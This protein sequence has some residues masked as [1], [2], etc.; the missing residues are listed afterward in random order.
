VP[1]ITNELSAIKKICMAE[2]THKNIV[3]VFNCGQLLHFWY[4]ID[5]EL[6]DLN[7]ERWIYRTWDVATAKKLPF[8]T[9]EVSS[10]V[11]M[12]QTWDIMQDVS[13]AVSFIHSEGLIHRDLKPS[14]S[15]GTLLEPRL[16]EFSFI[17]S[18]RQGLESWGFRPYDGRLVK[19]SHHDLG[20]TRYRRL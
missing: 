2:H 5:M 9:K 8:F 15:K 12:R 4:F 13:E 10:Q 1:N 6:C 16:T 17:F 7:L 14:N 19:K 18:Q 3:S 20:G 11:K